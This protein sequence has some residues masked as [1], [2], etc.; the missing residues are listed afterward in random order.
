M[1]LTNGLHEDGNMRDIR[2]E[3]I[4]ARLE[5]LRLSVP[6]PKGAVHALP[7]RGFSQPEVVTRHPKSSQYRCSCRLPRRAFP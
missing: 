4:H 1:T 2:R 5:L 6:L 7:L 3:R